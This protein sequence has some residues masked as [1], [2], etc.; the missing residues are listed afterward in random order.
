MLLVFPFIASADEVHDFDMDIYINSNGDAYITEVWDATSDMGSEFYHS[1]Y[2]YDGSDFSDFS[3][4]MD[5]KQYTFIDDW[6]VDGSLE[7]KQYKNGFNYVENGIEI[8]FGKTS[9]GR[10]KY[11][12][13]YKIT[14]FVRSLNDSD[15]IYWTLLPYN[16]GGQF[17]SV[18]VNIYSDF[19]YDDDTQFYLYG[20][21]GMEVRN[22]DGNIEISSNGSLKDSEYV[23]ILVKFDK[24]TFDLSSK[25]DEDLVIT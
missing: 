16:N 15:M 10:H 18:N 1:Y 6:D 3:V 19:K 21:G 11:I 9:F 24:N 20:K 12:S 22:S 25:L 13:K 2:N 7:D 4:S 23:T 8:C 14:N 5:N 17:K